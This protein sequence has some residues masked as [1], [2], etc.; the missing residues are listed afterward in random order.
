MYIARHVSRLADRRNC[1][2]VCISW[3]RYA[4]HTIFDLGIDDSS[5]G[6][7][8]WCYFGALTM[9]SYKELCELVCMCCCPS[10]VS[11][12]RNASSTQL[13][14][15][16]EEKTRSWRSNTNSEALE[17]LCVPNR[18]TC[19]P[20]EQNDAAEYVRFACLRTYLS[21]YIYLYIHMYLSRI[22]GK[23]NLYRG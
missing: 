18:N 7:I 16:P 1:A 12:P 15:S 13:L 22:L 14:V 9:W 21:L 5:W 11:L 8:C 17:E 10:L 4:V 23:Q 6:A 2:C 3:L 19:V 20:I